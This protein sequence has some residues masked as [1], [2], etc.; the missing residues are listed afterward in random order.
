[1]AAARQR[2]H[3]LEQAMQTNLGGNPVVEKGQF[4]VWVKRGAVPVNHTLVAYGAAGNKEFRAGTA[5]DFGQRRAFPSY[6]LISLSP[7]TFSFERE[8]ATDDGLFRY[9]I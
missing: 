5:P 8:Y 1:M 6:A 3:F 4:D 7:Q 2:R 9:T